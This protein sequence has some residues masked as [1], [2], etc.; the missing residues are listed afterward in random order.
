[1]GNKRKVWIRIRSEQHSIS[2]DST[3]RLFMDYLK[4][5]SGSDT[6]PEEPEE[7]QGMIEFNS[8]GIAEHTDGSLL[9]SYEET[10]LSGMEGSVTSVSF[11]DKDPGVVTMMRDGTVKTVLV[12]EEGK[13]N[14]CVYNTMF[15]P[16]EL[17]VHTYVLRNSLTEDGGELYLD[18]VLEMQGGAFERSKF[19]MDVRP[20][21]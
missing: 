8:E 19:Q 6:E 11:C 13:R 10:E 16:F 20:V 15:I 21:E 7:D 9:F 1:M 3:R 17:A 2:A 14:I 4:A 5:L 12:F 18:Y